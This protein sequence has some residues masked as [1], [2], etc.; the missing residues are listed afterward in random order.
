MRVEDT[1]RNL[2]DHGGPTIARRGTA[3]YAQGHHQEHPG[4]QDQAHGNRLLR[5]IPDE[6]PEGYYLD[7]TAGHRYIGGGEGLAVGQPLHAIVVGQTGTSRSPSA[8][9]TVRERFERSLYMLH[10]HNIT[11]VWSHGRQV[12]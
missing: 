6:Y 2:H 5:G 4:Y 11:A 12:K 10:R 8:T 1:A 7:T 9:Q 3:P